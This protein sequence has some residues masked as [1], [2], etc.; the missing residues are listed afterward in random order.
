MEHMELAKFS[1]DPDT[2][3][4]WDFMGSLLFFFAQYLILLRVRAHHG[5]G[6]EQPEAWTDGVCYKGRE[7][8]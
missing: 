3:H 5:C 6:K 4:L 1:A 7:E 8:T 2:I